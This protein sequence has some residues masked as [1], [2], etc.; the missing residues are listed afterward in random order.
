MG[1]A[2]VRDVTERSV[3]AMR[4]F[5][6]PRVKWCTEVDAIDHV[7]SSYPPAFNGSISALQLDRCITESSSPLK[8]EDIVPKN[9][10]KLVPPSPDGDPKNWQDFWNSFE[11]SIDKKDSLSQGEKFAYLK[12]LLI[13]QAANVASG[14]ELTSDNYVNCVK[15]LK[16]RFGKRD[17]IINSFMNKILNLESVKYSSNVRG[18]RKLYDQLDVSVRNL[19]SMNATSGSY[20]HLIKPVLLKLIPNDLVLEFHRQKKDGREIDVSE[21]IRFLRKEIV[22]RNFPFNFK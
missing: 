19:D 6:C 21:L 10:D 11:S 1:S 12:S 9:Y 4:T 7:G 5:A 22:S 14:F 16:E 2:M 15:S 18:L 17:V 8:F 13:G 3:T 20:G